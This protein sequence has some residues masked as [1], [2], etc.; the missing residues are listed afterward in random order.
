[1]PDG[2]SPFRRLVASTT[3]TNAGLR[4]QQFIVET[5]TCVA[6]LCGPATARRTRSAMFERNPQCCN[7]LQTHVPDRK[8]HTSLERSGIVQT[9]GIKYLR[10]S[11]RE[12]QTRQR[13][14]QMPRFKSAGQAQ[15]FLSLHDGVRNLFRVGRHLLRFAG[16]LAPLRGDGINLIY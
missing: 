1:M 2:S 10:S 16:V 3:V 14:R 11:L 15:R 6:H 5:P 12:P 4:N 8:A 13:E 7:Y 9:L